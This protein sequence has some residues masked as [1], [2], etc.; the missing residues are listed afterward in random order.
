MHHTRIWSPDNVS[1]LFCTLQLRMGGNWCLERLFY[2]RKKLTTPNHSSLLSIVDV[3]QEICGVRIVLLL[4][5]RPLFI[6]KHV[7]LN[8][9]VIVPTVGTRISCHRWVQRLYALFFCANWMQI[10]TLWY[11]FNCGIML[12]L[13]L[14]IHNV[15]TSFCSSF[16]LYHFKIFQIL[17]HFISYQSCIYWSHGCF[18]IWKCAVFL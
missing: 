9:F 16:L 1:V 18:I 6:F 10:H 8:V 2:E 12:S 14:L 11:L 15:I 5:L 13:N 3:L 4:P 7:P 17:I